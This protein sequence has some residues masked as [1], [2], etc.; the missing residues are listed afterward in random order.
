MNCPACKEVMIVLELESIEVDHCVACGGIWLDS[1]ELELL[2]EGGQEKEELLSS[3]RF[4]M[5]VKE[6]KKKCPMCSKKMDHVLLG[7]D[8]GAR[9]DSCPKKH[10][11]W[12]D[13]GELQVILKHAQFQQGSTL[14]HLLHSIFSA[15]QKGTGF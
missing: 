13:S 1:G 2:L 15:K 10:G 11:L 9:L 12:C 4:D 7:Q 14:I 5:S 8:F 6:P 3:I